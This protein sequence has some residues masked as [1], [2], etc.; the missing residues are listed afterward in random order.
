[1]SIWRSLIAEFDAS[2]PRR[3]AV[4]LKENVTT[5]A[6][7]YPMD[8]GKIGYRLDTRIATTY[9]EKPT[10]SFYL[11]DYVRGDFVNNPVLALNSFY[12]SRM[13]TAPNWLRRDYGFPNVGIDLEETASIPSDQG[14]VWSLNFKQRNLHKVAD[15]RFHLVVQGQGALRLETAEAAAPDDTANVKLVKLATEDGQSLSIAIPADA[16]VGLFE[17]VDAYSQAIAGESIPAPVA[18]TGSYVVIGFRVHFEKVK[19]SKDWK[20]RRFTVAF[21]T[22]GAKEAAESYGEDAEVRTE[23]LWNGFFGRLPKL[24]L[25][26]EEAERMYYKCWTV[27]KQNYYVHPEW[28]F[29]ILEALP[30]Y[31]GAW[32]WGTSAIVSNS[33]LDPDHPAE[34]ARNSLNLFTRNMRQD[35]YLTHAIYIDEKEPG[36]RWGQGEGVIQTPHLPWVAYAY[37]EKTK[38]LEQLR[39]WYPLFVRFYDYIG[40]TRDEGLDRLHLWAAKTSFDI[41]LDV[42]PQ[43]TDITY[44]GETHAYSAVFAAERV[45]YERTMADIA[46]LLGHRNE[47]TAWREAADL[48]LEAA[49]RHLWDAEAGWYGA[50]RADGTLD[51]RVSVD[52]LAFL[53]YGLVDAERAKAMKPG[54][55]KLIATYGVRTFAPDELEYEPDVYWRGPAWP[56]SCAWGAE[57]V[58]RYYPDLRERTLEALIRFAFRH[59]NIWECMNPDNGEIARGD[60]G[61]KATPGVSSNVGAGELISALRAFVRH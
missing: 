44:Y 21:S 12:T 10:F 52:G 55:E 13:R 60:V 42:S 30:V 46:D 49:N 3:T 32:M 61:V 29:M 38:D 26:R 28:G 51:T 17:S 27:I 41:G 48:S 6:F 45:R 11:D 37:Y 54:V 56:K 4:L 35:G 7:Y 16:E 36:E 34:Y 15:H 24:G 25:G 33:L 47:S 22:L 8:F 58:C 2:L 14:L 9:E 40:R 53:A 59:P 5:T 1:M 39:T 43:F 18:E 57:A 20:T 23:R 31:K 50:R 19:S